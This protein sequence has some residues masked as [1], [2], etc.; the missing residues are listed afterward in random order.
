MKR[1]GS[2]YS[3]LRAMVARAV[4]DGSPGEADIAGMVAELLEGYQ[5]S[6]DI[7]S[8]DPEEDGELLLTSADFREVARE[9]GFEV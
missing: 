3:T 5:G 6:M 4:C 8:T 1:M 2:P 7:D 9:H